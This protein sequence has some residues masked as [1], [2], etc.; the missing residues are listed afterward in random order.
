MLYF[1]IS[2]VSLLFVIICLLA[3]ANDLRWKPGL[4]WKMRAVGLT[5]GGFAAFGVI[6]SEL[7]TQQWPTPYESFF[8]IGIALTLIT[9]PNGIPF[10]KYIF[11][12]EVK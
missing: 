3:R 9:T 2:T 1:L 11:Q 7:I 10:W 6:G 12:G 4:V 5:I 8:R